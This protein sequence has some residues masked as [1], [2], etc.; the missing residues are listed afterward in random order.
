VAGALVASYDVDRKAIL[1]KFDPKT[2]VLDV[3]QRHPEDPDGVAWRVSVPPS[4]Y[5]VIEAY[6]ILKTYTM[7]NFHRKFFVPVQGVRP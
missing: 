4:H 7:V 5:M 2:R 1:A 3:E 6:G